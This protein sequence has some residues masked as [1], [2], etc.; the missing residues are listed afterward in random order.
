MRVTPGEIA[1]RDGRLT[2]DFED[3]EGQRLTLV[4][5]GGAGVAY[6]WERSPVAGDQP[7]SRARPDPPQR[8]ASCSRP[9]SCSPQAL[10]MR[11]EREYAHP[12]N[13]QHTV[14]VFAMGDGGVAAE[15]H[16]AE[17]PGLPT[18]NKARAV[19]TMSPSARRR[20]SSMTPGPSA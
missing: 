7:D 14:H 20:S 4:D 15:V 10:N 19:S 17:Q 13:A 12:D 3:P 6:P 5:D 9:R 16:V 1:E 8:A 2:L 11:L 18:P